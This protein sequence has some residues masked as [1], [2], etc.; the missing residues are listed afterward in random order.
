MVVFASSNGD[1]S[2]TE[3]FGTKQ[4]LITPHLWL[5]TLKHQLTQNFP[6]LT[7]T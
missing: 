7:T 6:W 4:L 1:L 5:S 2:K 3:N